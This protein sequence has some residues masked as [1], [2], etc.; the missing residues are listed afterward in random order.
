M[1]KLV[2]LFIVLLSFNL[3]ANAGDDTPIQFNQLPATA[4]QFVKINF[5]D[6][7][8]ALIKKDSGFFDTSYDVIFTNG[9]KVEFDKKGN[10][11]KV[12]SQ[13]AD[14][15][16]AI[17]PSQINTYLNNTY[18]NVAVVQIEKTDRNGYEIDLS[19]NIELEFN[20]LFKLISID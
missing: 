11:T 7:P 2:F 12:Y 1:K 18:P 4:I 10:W 20:N 14:F 3:A 9:D 5:K 19:N 8:I 17:I 6:R 13:K 16:V 15:P